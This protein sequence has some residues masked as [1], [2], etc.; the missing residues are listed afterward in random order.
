MLLQTEMPQHN[1]LLM[2]DATTPATSNGGTPSSTT[3]LGTNA[4]AT[5]D[6]TGVYKVSMYSTLNSGGILAPQA[7]SLVGN[8]VAHENRMPYLVLNFCIALYGVF[9]SRN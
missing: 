1:H 6:P 2:A 8:N 5:T 3:V 9:P 7:L 4:G